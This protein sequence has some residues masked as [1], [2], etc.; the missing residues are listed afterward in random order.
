MVHYMTGKEV[1]YSK[2]GCGLRSVEGQEPFEFARW[3]ER[4]KVTCPECLHKINH[5]NY[6][7]RPLFDRGLKAEIPSPET[8]NGS[9][10]IHYMKGAVAPRSKTGC[11]IRSVEGKEN[12]EYVYWADREQVTCPDC[13]VK[14]AKMMLLK[15]P[16]L[17]PRDM[18]P[19]VL[20]K[21]SDV[22]LYRRV[23]DQPEALGG[24]AGTAKGKAKK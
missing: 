2:T 5:P 15:R 23:S 16:E 22:K 10:I 4:G 8:S 13:Q 7:M 3:A 18:P 20:R 11:E 24:M 19:D 21:D 14:I 12:F 6:S 1:T 17:L 9:A